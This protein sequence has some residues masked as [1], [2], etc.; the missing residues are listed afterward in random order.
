[1]LTKISY[2]AWDYIIY[3]GYSYN[4]GEKF[5]LHFIAEVNE[6]IS[7]KRENSKTINYLAIVFKF[8]YTSNMF[9]I[10]INVIVRELHDI[11]I[12]IFLMN[13]KAEK[14]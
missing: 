10:C 8:I 4:V 6:W 12:E 2:I 9:Q 13:E 1:M 3:E 5:F 14:K 11:F 7:K